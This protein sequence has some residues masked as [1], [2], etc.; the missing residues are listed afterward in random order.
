MARTL[1]VSSRQRSPGGASEGRTAEL[2]AVE[3]KRAVRPERE[4]DGRR[5]PAAGSKG[6]SGDPGVACAERELDGEPHL[7][8]GS[9]AVIAKCDEAFNVGLV[10]ARG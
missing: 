10:P 8:L 7:L 4:P 5:P 1:I 9:G 6:L 3:Q 2:L